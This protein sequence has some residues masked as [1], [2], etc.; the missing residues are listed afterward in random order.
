M[1]GI[2][3]ILDVYTGSCGEPFPDFSFI[4]YYAYCFFVEVLYYM[5]E[6]GIDIESFHCIPKCAMPYPIESFYKVNEYMI[7]RF[8]MFGIFIL[9][10]S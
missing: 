9:N 3:N 8:F 6:C 5:Y 4:V 2:I 10:Y 1:L 7:K